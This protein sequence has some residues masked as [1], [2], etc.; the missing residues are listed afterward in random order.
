MLTTGAEAQT[1]ITDLVPHIARMEGFHR[2]YM[3]SQSY[4]F[5]SQINHFGDPFDF[6]FLLLS[7]QI[8]ATLSSHLLRSFHLV[9]LQFYKKN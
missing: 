5:S 3:V 7:A 9:F 8:I 2:R 4:L 1:P 6:V